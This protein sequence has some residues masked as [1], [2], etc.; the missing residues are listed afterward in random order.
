MTKVET[1]GAGGLACAAAQIE[2][3]LRAVAQAA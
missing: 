1:A 2:S 3:R